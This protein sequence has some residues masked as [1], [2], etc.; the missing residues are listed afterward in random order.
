MY[1]VLQAFASLT[2]TTPTAIWSR[3]HFWRF[4]N[5][6]H[7]KNS[8]RV[9]FWPKSCA[10]RIASIGGR[11]ATR[12]AGML[13]DIRVTDMQTRSDTPIH[14]VTPYL[15]GYL[16]CHHHSTLTSHPTCS[17]VYIVNCVLI[18]KSH[19]RRTVWGLKSLRHTSFQASRHRI[20]PYDAVPKAIFHCV[21]TLLELN[22]PVWTLTTDA[23][24]FSSH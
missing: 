18:A 20:Y 2:P 17:G 21:I 13:P 24:S 1:K 14:N 19:S 9:H 6:T 7:Q 12:L 22:L 5:A 3:V 23:T 16:T 15:F 8:S 10:A 11:A 4:L